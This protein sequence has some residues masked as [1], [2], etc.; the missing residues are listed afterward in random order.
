MVGS[1][2]QLGVFSVACSEYVNF[3]HRTLH[4]PT[5]AVK[6]SQRPDTN[7]SIVLLR[8]TCWQIT[9]MVVHSHFADAC[10]DG[11]QVLP[12]TTLSYVLANNCLIAF[13]AACVLGRVP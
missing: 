12:D 1:E 6:K 10:P 13:S 3:H 7:S 11:V 5:P 9:V 4:R 2:F 8:S